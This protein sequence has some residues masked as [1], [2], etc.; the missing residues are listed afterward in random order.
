M[1][2]IDYIIKALTLNIKAEIMKWTAL[3]NNF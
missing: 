1:M 2:K 3:L